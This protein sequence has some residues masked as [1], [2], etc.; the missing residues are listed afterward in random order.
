MK[1]TFT[2]KEV[3]TWLTLV[4]IIVSLKI[5][6]YTSISWFIILMPIYL[7]IVL[8]LILM[9]GIVALRTFWK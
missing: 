7:P 4:I 9:A 3:I 6:G 5:S 8:L 1:I 2:L